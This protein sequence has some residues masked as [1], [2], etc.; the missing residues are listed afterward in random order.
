MRC[1]VQGL[2]LHPCL[3]VHGLLVVIMRCRVQ[4]LGL[5]PCLFVH[6]LLVVISTGRACGF[7]ILCN[8][9]I[10]ERHTPGFLTRTARLYL[11]FGIQGLG[12]RG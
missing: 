8:G 4:G 3:F 12:F 10:S 5:H 9:S 2:G 6:G 7:R 11:A 1:R